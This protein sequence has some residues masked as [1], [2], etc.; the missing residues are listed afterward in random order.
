MHGSPLQ[1]MLSEMISSQVTACLNNL[2]SLPANSLSQPD[3]LASSSPTSPK[4]MVP[5]RV[6][7][8][9]PAERSRGGSLGQEAL[10]VQ[11]G[12]RTMFVDTPSI[13]KQS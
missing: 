12:K 13:P 1:S 8:A 4:S 2:A 9:L 6:Q 5:S 7:K 11:S 10:R 3:C